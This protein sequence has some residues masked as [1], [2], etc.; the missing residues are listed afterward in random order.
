MTMHRLPS[1]RWFPHDWLTF[2]LPWMSKHHARRVL[3][4]VKPDVVHIQSHIVIGRGLAR[5][6][7][8][9]GI[10]IIATNHVMAENILD[11]TTLP[12]ALN[13]V[14]VK[15]AWADAKRT[16]DMT[17]AVTTPTRKAADFLEATID[18]HGVIPISCGIDASNYRPISTPRD[19]QPHPVRRPADHR[20]AHR[21]PA[22]GGRAARPR[23]RRARRHRRRAATSART[24]RS[25]TTR[26]GSTRRVTF[27]GHATEEELRALYSRASL[28]AIASIAELQSIATMEAMAS[29]LPIVAAD[30][31]ALPHLVHDGENGYLF[32]PGNVEELAARL[33]D[34][35]TA[36]PEERRRMQQASLDGVKIHDINRTLDTFEALYR[37]E[38][39][40]A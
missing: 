13:D 7:R 32:E 5:E 25:S 3:D 23:A 33:T 2:V 14:F 9:R 19:A 17:R 6:A 11:F 30:A 31:V 24:S 16:F 15:L 38:P 20:E 37:G 27:H 12:H 39:L 29:G 40:P 21:R 34:V 36:A 10:P 18:I 28:F 8:K 26:S 35:L 1:W 22:E 4:A